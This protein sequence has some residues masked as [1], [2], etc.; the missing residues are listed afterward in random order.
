MKKIFLL[1]VTCF[2]VTLSFG[3][4]IRPINIY[5]TNPS[6][7]S[8]D[9]LGAQCKVEGIVTSID[10]D[11]NNGYYFFVQDSTA[12]ILI[13]SFTNLNSYSVS[14][15]DKLRLIGEIQQYNGSTRIDVDSIAF[16]SSNN[17]IPAPQV[18]NLLDESTEGSL[19][20]LQGVSLASGQ[21][22]PNTAGT[23]NL[24]L[25]TSLGAT[26]IM[27]LDNDANL[28]PSVA[29][30]NGPFDV[31]G[32]VSQYGSD[33]QLYPRIPTDID[34]C[35]GYGRLG[36]DSIVACN[37]HTWINGATYTS[38]NT[39]ATKTL[40]TA[41]G[42]DSVV[43]L[44]LTINQAY[45]TQAS[46]TICDNEN[47]TTAGNQTVS[48]A[49]VY[50]DT[51]S[52][53]LTCDSVIETTINANPSYFTQVSATIC[54]NENYT[55]AGNQTVSVA[56]V[57]LDTFS[58]VLACDSVIET[59]LNV[60]ITTHDSLIIDACIGTFSLSGKYF[61]ATGIYSDTIS[62]HLGCDSIIQYD[63]TISSV[64]DSVSYYDGDKLISHDSASYYQWLSCDFNF[65]KV[66]NGTSMIFAPSSNGSYAV[67]VS[68]GACRDTSDCFLI[69]NVSIES[70]L[71]NNSEIK[72][73]PN[74]TNGI[75]TID[76]KQFQKAEV[77]DAKGRLIIKSKSNTIDLEHQPKGLYFIKVFTEGIIEEFKLIKD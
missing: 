48:V 58:S 37:S 70:D 34:P 40:S 17:T 23:H 18:V 32:C 3:Q 24:N 77:F 50:L 49:G 62:N 4:T 9:S 76:A 27:R 38:N 51:L 20:T 8:L 21:G 43:T 57:Y 11:G 16:I 19:V 73:Y 33:Y 66:A 14:M 74:P 39:S 52:S 41:R 53:V 6:T 55:T 65:S 28:T 36:S 12:G 64:N 68:K 69:Q 22:W 30:P 26:I 13:Y 59:T 5:T 67:E 54:D 61:N 71:V 75:V 42:C 45:F 25:V 63:L 72:L 2:I 31:I 7:G 35:Y 60:L 47:Y 10:F 29:A 1:T 56:G 44:N 46:A 15:G